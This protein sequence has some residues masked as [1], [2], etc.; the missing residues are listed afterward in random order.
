MHIGLTGGIGCGKTSVLEFFRQNGW[1]VFDSDKFCRKLREDASGSL[2]N[3]IKKRWGEKFLSKNGV[4]DDSKVAKLIFADE[5]ERKWLNSVVHPLVLEAMRQKASECEDLISDVP[6][7]F[8]VGWEKE[9]DK[10]ITVWAPE[11]IR[12]KRLKARGMSEAEAKQRMS[13]QFSADK[14]LEMADKGIINSGSIE[15]LHEQCS[16]LIK[17][18]KKVTEKKRRC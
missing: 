15:L 9:F 8:E 12:I 7:L 6:L 2:V 5:T 1:S 11:E 3:E 4:P 17:D 18:L 14:K 13:S 10:I 16:K